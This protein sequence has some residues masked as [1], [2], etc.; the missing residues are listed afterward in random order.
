[1]LGQVLTARGSFGPM[2]WAPIVN[3]VVAI[4]TGLV[5][6]RPVHGR[7][8]FDPSSL[9][10]GAIALLGAGTT[11][12]VALQALVLVPVLRRS[13]FGW[14]P[15]LRLPRGR[16]GPGRRPGQVD[17]AV[18]AGQPA[19]VRRHR[20][21]RRCARTSTPTAELSYGVGY[22]AYAN[23]YLI[24]ILPHSIITVSVV[25]GLLPAAEP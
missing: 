6:H 23:A 20:Q 22:A 19:R 3:N 7:P 8:E 15:R 12:G 21:P 5:V 9:S 14:R 16:P 11:L 17:L 24:F 10:T 4:V 18:R 2:M 13:G 25:T 1:M